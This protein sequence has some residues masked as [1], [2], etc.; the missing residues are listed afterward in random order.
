MYTIE[1]FDTTCFFFVLFGLNELASRSSHSNET[2]NDIDKTI[3][4]SLYIAGFW[5]RPRVVVG[6]RHCRN[7]YSKLG[8]KATI[9]AGV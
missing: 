4:L 9:F 5:L 3:C 2:A 1:N 6:D 8:D 7:Y